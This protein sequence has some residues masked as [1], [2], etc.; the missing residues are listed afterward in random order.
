MN[1]ETECSIG[2]MVWVVHN[3]LIQRGRVEKVHIEEI[4]CCDDPVILYTVFISSS[5]T[6]LDT[7]IERYEGFLFSKKEDILKTYKV[8]S[9]LAPTFKEDDAD[10]ELGGKRTV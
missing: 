3:S 4:R 1:I 2:D 10:A 7:S 8:W 6:S 9:D 5:K